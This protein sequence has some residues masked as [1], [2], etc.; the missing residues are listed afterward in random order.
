[1]QVHTSTCYILCLG[2]FILGSEPLV[3]VKGIIALLTL[4]RGSWGL[5]WLN[6]A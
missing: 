6:M 1:M 5:S 4:Y 2:K 3:P